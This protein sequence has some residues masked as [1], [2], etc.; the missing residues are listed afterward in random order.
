MPIDLG[1]VWN[2]LNN[3][4]EAGE[5]FVEDQ[6]E[7]LYG[8]IHGK[9]QERVDLTETKFDDNGLK[10]VELGL[11]DKLLKIYPLDQYPLD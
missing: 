8:T 9:L 1:A 2:V 3:L 10:V 6:V 4:L 7:N 11:R 5:G